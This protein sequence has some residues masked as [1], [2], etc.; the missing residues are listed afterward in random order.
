MSLGDRAGPLGIFV[1]ECVEQL[2]VFVERMLLMI[3]EQGEEVARHY[4]SR[5]LDLGQQPR[6][7]CGAVD[8][9]VEMPVGLSDAVV[10]RWVNTQV[11][12]G[13]TPATR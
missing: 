7:V 13:I 4:A 8:L 12:S 10:T 3:G 11:I 5:L 1:T 9:L 6:G 2:L